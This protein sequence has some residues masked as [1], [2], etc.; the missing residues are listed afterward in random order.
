MLLTV[1]ESIR[2]EWGALKLLGPVSA[3]LLDGLALLQGQ[4]TRLEHSPESHVHD[5]ALLA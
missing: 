2:L 1:P 4:L 3:A 5:A